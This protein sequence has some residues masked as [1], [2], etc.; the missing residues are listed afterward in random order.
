MGILLGG[1]VE[2]LFG[3][4][5]K[6]RPDRILM[7]GGGGLV[8]HAVAGNE[9]IIRNRRGAKIKLLDGLGVV[10]VQIAFGCVVDH[11]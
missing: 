11:L 2:E 9:A 1:N 5:V 4:G 3:F 7:R 10:S 6:G 8:V